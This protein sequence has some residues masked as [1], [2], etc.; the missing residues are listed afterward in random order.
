MDEELAAESPDPMFIA[1]ADDDAEHLQ[2]VEYWVSA[3]PNAQVLTC[4]QL[5]NFQTAIRQQI[6]RLRNSED[7]LD[8]EREKKLRVLIF[9]D[10]IWG[11]GHNP[12]LGL[13]FLDALRNDPDLQCYPVIIYSQTNS[14]DEVKQCYCRR[15]S[16]FLTKGPHNG[17][18]ARQRFVKVVETWREVMTLPLAENVL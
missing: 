15:A 9:L 10:L 3:L 7:Q 18:D 11:V 14:D 12:A 6:Q 2:F 8:G 1:I 13:N 4:P 17:I 16:G 5:Q